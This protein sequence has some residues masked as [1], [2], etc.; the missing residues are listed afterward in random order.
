MRKPVGN[1]SWWSKKKGG[2]D[3]PLFFKGEEDKG[4][5]AGK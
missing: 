4:G 5:E 1:S 3:I 2:R